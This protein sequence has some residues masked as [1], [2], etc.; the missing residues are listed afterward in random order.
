[1]V[2]LNYIER[3]YILEAVRDFQDVVAKNKEHSARPIVP[4]DLI[5]S[6]AD[7]VYEVLQNNAARRLRD[8]FS[9]VKFKPGKGEQ[10]V[11]N[12]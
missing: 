6:L 1:M 5:D 12:Q 2:Q 7:R 9:E 8:S 10:D 3:C 4:Q 11:N